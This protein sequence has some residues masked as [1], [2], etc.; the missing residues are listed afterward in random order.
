MHDFENTITIRHLVHHIS[1][2][3]GDELRRFVGWWG[4]SSNVRNL[5]ALSRSRTLNFQSG[6]EYLYENFGYLVLA[7]IVE[8]VSGQS[9]REFTEENIF[10]P[11]GMANTQFEDDY[12]MVVKNRVQS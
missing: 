7:E 12:S 1:G 4:T 11:L 8:R 5:A 2:L 9:L 6:E 3:R 10:G